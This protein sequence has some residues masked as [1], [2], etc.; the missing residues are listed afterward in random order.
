IG[1]AAGGFVLIPTLGMR[2]TV[3]VAAGGYLIIAALVFVVDRFR[4]KEPAEVSP[5]TV[6]GGVKTTRGEGASSPVLCI[7]LFFFGL[8]GFASLVYENAWTRALTLVIGSSIYSFTTMLVTFL[9]GLSLGGFI[10][11]RFLG[12]REARLSTFG[13]IELWVGLA[14]LATIPLFERLP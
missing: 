12:G 2:A 4:G 3:F 8:S 5:R 6:A 13:L 9:I 7:L 14:A 10:Y 1:C 11:A